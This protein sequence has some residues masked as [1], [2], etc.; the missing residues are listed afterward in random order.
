LESREVELS[1]TTFIL[2][3]INFVVLVWLLKRLFYAPVKR[4]IAARRAAVEKTLQDA[5]AA[6]LRAEELKA[7]YEGRLR[8]WEEEKEHQR[9]ELRKELNQERSRQLTLIETSVATEREKAEAQEEKKAAERRANVEKEAMQ[10]ALQFTSRLL[11]DLASPELEGKIVDLVT[12]R[13]A[14]SDERDLP[15]AGPQSGGRRMTVQVRSAYSLTEPQ[16]NA[17]F[18]ALGRRLGADVPVAFD[19]DQKLLAGLEI[20][21]GSVVL[22]A[23]LRDELKYFSAASNHD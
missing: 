10:Q 12:R 17:L 19:V 18:A 7:K 6:K 20:A 11:S 15:I 4:T 13:I 22:R 5:E 21:V 1:W 23:N 3:A 16:R 8:E 2:E 14:S 9:E